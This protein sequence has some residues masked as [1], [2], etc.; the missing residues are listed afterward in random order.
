MSKSNAKGKGN[1]NLIEILQYHVD[2]KRFIGG[3][4]KI[5]KDGSIRKLNGQVFA[6][7][8]TKSGLCSVVIDNFL[9]KRRKGS[10]KRWQLVLTKNL[11]CLSENKWRH[12]KVKD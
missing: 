7:K 6:I 4:A 1:R 8:T 11:L 2:S 3:L 10:T 5:E 12:E 9:H